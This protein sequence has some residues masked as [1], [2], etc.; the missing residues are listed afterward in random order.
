ML[1]LSVNTVYFTVFSD[2]LYL[3]IYILFLISISLCFFFFFFFSSRRRHTRFDCDWSSDVCSSD[4]RR[5]P[6]HG[7]GALDP[8]LAPRGPREGPEDRRDPGE[9]APQE[10]S[11][12]GHVP[13]APQIGR[14]SCRERV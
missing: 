4:L 6:R 2:S 8:P 12:A 1:Y 14:A 13:L 10:G 5:R 9:P 3:F 7:H 11:E